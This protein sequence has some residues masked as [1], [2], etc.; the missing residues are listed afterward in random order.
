VDPPVV[1]TLVGL[2]VGTAAG[3]ALL[4]ALDS[5]GALLCAL[6]FVVAVMGLA[7]YA[8]LTRSS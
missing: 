6:G 3:G 7:V 8:G 1:W 5:P 4:A 2:A